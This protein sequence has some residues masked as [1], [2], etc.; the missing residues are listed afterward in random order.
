MFVTLL[1]LLALTCGAAIALGLLIVGLFEAPGLLLL[2]LLCMGLLG[3]QRL[4]VY[5]AAAEDSDVAVSAAT[6]SSTTE[7][8]GSPEP[9][10]NSGPTYTYRGVKYSSPS[11]EKPKGESTTTTEGIYRGQPWRRTNADTSESSSPASSSQPEIKYRGHNV[12]K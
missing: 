9:A 7:S 5:V 6:S 4:A 8:S 3:L 12:R 10:A 11:P 2:V 1:L